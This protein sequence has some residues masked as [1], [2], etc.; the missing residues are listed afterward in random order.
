MRSKRI[1]TLIASVASLTVAASCFTGLAC[2]AA[3][4]VDNDV[5]KPTV[6]SAYSVSKPQKNANKT[7]ATSD[8]ANFMA[9]S[10]TENALNAS[11]KVMTQNFMQIGNK[12]L[13]EAAKSK[14][15]FVN[16]LQTSLASVTCIKIT[17]DA[18]DN[19]EYEVGYST[20]APY[21][22]NITFLFPENGVCYLTGLRI[23]SEYEITVSPIIKDGEDLIKKPAKTT[24]RTPN[25]AVIQNFDYEDGWTG[26]FAGERASGLTA[27]PSSGAIYGSYCDTITGTGIRR[28]DNGDYCCA[29]GTHY[30]YCGDRFLIELENGI[31]FTVRICDS[32]GCGD[33]QDEWGGGKYHWFGGAGNGKCIIEFI[34]HDSALPGCV[35][36]AG[37]WG[38]WNWN[39][40]NLCSNIRNIQKL[41]DYNT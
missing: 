38:N 12:S 13:T 26:C 29:M 14:I 41:A 34:Y 8:S 20:C 23:D 31:Q 17:W 27:M 30:G 40:L 28:F 10:D 15:A 21:A 11:L 37:S 33:V 24:V 36:F 2:G 18:E 9:D 7:S 39:G 1:K 5:T 35:R 19:R 3:N 4:E 16:N 25:P 6:A 32:K 22:E